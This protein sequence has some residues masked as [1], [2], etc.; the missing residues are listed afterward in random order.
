MGEG[1]KGWGQEGR[2]RVVSLPLFIA[3]SRH[4]ALCFIKQLSNKKTI[5]K[6][7]SLPIVCKIKQNIFG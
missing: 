7:S 1:M 6:G 3:R 4:S 5:H 2:E